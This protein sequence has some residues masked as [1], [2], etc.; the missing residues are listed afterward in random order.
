MDSCNQVTITDA[1]F[2]HLQGIRSLGLNDCNQVANTDAAFVHLQG[3]RSLGMN[4]CNQATI[5]GAAFVYLRGIKLNNVFCR[6]AG[7]SEI[8]CRVLKSCVFQ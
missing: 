2:A 5:T 1:A 6:R 7:K 4:G 8:S 3:I